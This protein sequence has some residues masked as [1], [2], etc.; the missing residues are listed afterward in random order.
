MTVARKAKYGVEFGEWAGFGISLEQRG[1]DNFTVRYGLQADEGLDY[2]S[3]AAKLGQAFMHALACEGRID[4]RT[5]AEAR[6]SVLGVRDAGV[7]GD[8]ARVRSAR[9]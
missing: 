6:G 2:A 3:A 8:R 4:N 1:V 5:K 9:D 7:G